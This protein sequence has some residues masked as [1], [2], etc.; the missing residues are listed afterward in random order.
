MRTAVILFCFTFC[1]MGMGCLF[2]A[3]GGCSSEP[4]GIVIPDPD[5]IPTP[6][7]DRGSG[8]DPSKFKRVPLD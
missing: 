5:T 3:S 2:L 6:G 1:Y 4:Q 7:S 8:T